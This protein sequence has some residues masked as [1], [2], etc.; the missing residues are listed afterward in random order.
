VQADPLGVLTTSRP[1]TT[2]TL[3]HLYG[4]ANQDP[5]GRILPKG[6]QSFLIGP[7]ASLVVGLGAEAG[8]GLLINPGIGDSCFDVGIYG[9][10]G[11]GWGVLASA[12][13]QVG[14]V[15]GAASNVT[16]VTANR[17]GP[18]NPDARISGEFAPE[19]GPEARESGADDEQ[20]VPT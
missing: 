15:P 17:A 12:G 11:I 5:L 10:G 1:S 16:G 2:T 9:T 8:F 4:Y 3:N 19:T 7:S 6:L 18:R 13:V 20:K 14:Y